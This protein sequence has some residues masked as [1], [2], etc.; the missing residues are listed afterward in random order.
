MA[1]SMVMAMVNHKKNGGN[2]KLINTIESQKCLEISQGF[3]MNYR[4]ILHFK[5]N[6]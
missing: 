1:V 5:K 6:L 4:Q 3:F 2:F